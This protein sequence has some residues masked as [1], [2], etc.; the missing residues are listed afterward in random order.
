MVKFKIWG[1]LR[2]LSHAETLRVFQRACAR[3]GINVQYSQGFNPHPKLSL[4][5]PR[6]VGVESDDE[7]LC[8]SV[9]DSGVGWGVPHHL[10]NGG[11]SPTLHGVARDLSAQLPEG[12]KII[13]VSVAEPGASIQPLAATYVLP[14]RPEH[15]NDKLR[16]TIDGLLASESLPV[17]RTTGTGNAKIKN[18]DAR[19]F[20]ASIEMTSGS[21]IV[22]CKISPAGSIRVDE[23]LS[24]LQLD[25]N[26]LAG[27]VRRT[28]VRWSES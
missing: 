25:Q 4:P 6:P 11:A 20:L 12:C 24:L 26:M 8:L 28:R 21:I 7:V 23:M 18:I 22:Q 2:F 17:R 19:G 3:A 15:L 16:T 14:V 9:R 10:A 27:P 13:S 1:A 5:L